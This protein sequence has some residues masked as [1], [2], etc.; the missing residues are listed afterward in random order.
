M[1][2]FVPA[3]GNFFLLCWLFSWWWN[4]LIF[5]F[6]DGCI[7]VSANHSRIVHQIG[8]VKPGLFPVLGLDSCHFGA[9][10]EFQLGGCL[11]HK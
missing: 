7:G 9:S 4:D 6:D 2:Y 1:Y 5:I 3:S 8:A 10:C 11:F